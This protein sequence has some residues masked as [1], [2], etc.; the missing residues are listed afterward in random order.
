[1]HSLTHW[2]H[3]FALF[4]FIAYPVLARINFPAL[5]KRVRE[6][7]EPAKIQAYVQTILTTLCFALILLGL[8]FWLQ[9]DWQSLGIRPAPLQQT[10]YGLVI[11]IAVLGFTVLQFR[12]MQREE[13]AKLAASLGDLAT[14]MPRT[15]REQVWFRLVSSNAGISEELLYRGFLIWYFSQLVD[16]WWAAGIAVLV[17]T[18]AHSYQGIKQVPGLLYISSVLVV[19]YLVSGSL[20]LPILFHAVYDMLQGFYIARLLGNPEPASG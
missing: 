9:R 8:W 1:M 17:F 2:D 13:M 6:S 19:L 18:F 4:V 15:E 3:L 12:A 10:V 5:A 20:L 11:C 7:G 16:V 14:L